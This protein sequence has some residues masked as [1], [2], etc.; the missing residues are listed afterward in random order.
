MRNPL[1]LFSCL[2]ELTK[3]YHNLVYGVNYNILHNYVFINNLI[4]HRYVPERKI[5][6]G[7]TF[8]VPAGQSV[9][10]VGTSGSGMG[11]FFI[12]QVIS[13]ASVTRPKI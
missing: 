8:T 10:I 9:A 1:K 6:D 5:L 13:N 3:D 4:S 7:A 12:Y 2:V 11:I